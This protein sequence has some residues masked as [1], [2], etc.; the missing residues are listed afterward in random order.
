MSKKRRG[1]HGIEKAAN[2]VGESKASQSE[3]RARHTR[4]LA[5]A[6]LAF[7]MAVGDDASMAQSKGDLI[8]RS[9]ISANAD[10]AQPKPN[11]LLEA[12][13]MEEIQLPVMGEI[14]AG[15]EN[16]MDRLPKGVDRERLVHFD[17][18][19]RQWFAQAEGDSHGVVGAEARQ[20]RI[21]DLIAQIIQAY[22][23][24]VGDSTPENFEIGS[25]PFAKLMQRINSVLLPFG[26][27]I[28]ESYDHVDKTKITWLHR[29]RQ[30]EVQIG[31][32][33]V[34]IV[35]VTKQLALLSVPESQIALFNGELNPQSGIA[36]LCE[37]GAEREMSKIKESHQIRC[38]K[39]K[40][41]ARTIDWEKALRDSLILP[42]YH[43]AAHVYFGGGVAFDAKRFDGLKKKGN[44]PMGPYSLPYSFVVSANNARLHELFANGVGLSKSGASAV[45]TAHG[46]ATNDHLENYFLARDVLWH[47]LMNSLDLDPAFRVEMKNEIE[48]TKIVNFDKMAVAID[49]LS[50]ESLHRIGER[51]A[52]LALYLIAE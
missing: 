39:E 32:E 47:E 48:R 5:W 37:E 23:V 18:Q 42:A 44:I 50:D 38:A 3:C 34:P 36:V 2:S 28:H 8:D 1:E 9:T 20:K 19:C 6:A 25:I 16:L 7:L 17:T 10:P 46:I 45:L 14:R 31:S 24:A 4:R 15:T 49:M 43:E 13:W 29:G 51:M 33:K 22:K 11:E 35:Y 41:V 52:K 12:H 26:D 27:F 30:A 40:R 21:F